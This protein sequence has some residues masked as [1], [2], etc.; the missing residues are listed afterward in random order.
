MTILDPSSTN[1]S[2]TAVLSY[3]PMPFEGGYDIPL[4]TIWPGAGGAPPP[5]QPLPVPMGSSGGIWPTVVGTA[6]DI[7]G[8]L[9]GSKASGPMNLPPLR[10]AGVGPLALPTIGA[11]GGATSAIIARYG[12][13]AAALARKYGPKILGYLAAGW[14]I[15]QIVG[16]IQ[17]GAIKP[18]ARRM[19]VLNPRAL[20]RSM[21]RVTGF[22]NFAKE[23]MSFSK[24][25]R[26]KTTRRKKRCRY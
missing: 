25:H 22:S 13:V 12:P 23:T 19:N 17:G 10:T 6:T 21:R 14:T 24:T 20:R 26:L 3:P 11:I 1:G 8:R 9:F 7:L 18:K 15:D 4:P 16:L 2:Y 5:L